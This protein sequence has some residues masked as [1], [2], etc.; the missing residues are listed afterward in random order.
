MS[1]RYHRGKKKTPPAQ[2]TI[3]ASKNTNA[4]LFALFADDNT[5]E[6]VNKALIQQFAR[7]QMYAKK[8]EDIYRI[9]PHHYLHVLNQNTNVTRVVE[10]PITFICQDHE[11][12]TTGVEKMIT[13]PPRSYIVIANP[14][15]RENKGDPAGTGAVTYDD[16]GMVLVRHGEKEVRL[17]Q[18]P[19]PLYPGEK[20]GKI[21]KLQNIYKNK[22]LRLRA[23]QDLVDRQGVQRYAGDEWLF[24]GPGTYIPH[25][26]IE[27]LGREKAQV[28]RENTALKLRAKRNTQDRQGVERVAG[29]EW[30]V[31]TVGAYLPGA[32][33]EVVEKVNAAVLTDKV[34]LHVEALKTFV[35]R[36]GQE[37][38]TG[39]CWLLTNQLTETF[40][41]SVNEKNREE[42]SNHDFDEQ[43]ILCHFGPI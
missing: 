12:V 24:E 19:F 5:D 29:E 36:F 13:V 16:N 34:A 32:Y 20:A 11:V 22:A 38:K 27:E 18:D 37:R 41:P 31:K 7:S 17:A 10:G 1:Q 43:A 33:E 35:D 21:Q 3:K 26:D 15:M 40:I 30:L 25:V 6:D 9:P 39:E 2:A 4:E 8:R 23:K 42:N 14:A 28:I